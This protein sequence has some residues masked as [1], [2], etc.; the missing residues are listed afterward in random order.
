MKRRILSIVTALALCLSL[1]PTWAFAVEGEPDTGLCA[2]HREH[3]GCGYIAPTEGR[4]CGHRHTAEC[5]TL[6]VLPDGDSSEYYETGAD[7]EIL[8]CQHAHD[9]ECGYVQAGPGAPCGYECR[10][11]PIEDL[12]AAL[13]SRVTEDNRADVGAQLQKILDLCQE[14]NEE[15]REQINLS[16]CYA[17]QAELDAANEPMPLADGETDSVTLAGQTQSVI[18][19]ETACLEGCKGHTITQQGTVIISPTILVESGTHNITFQDLNLTDAEVGVMPGAAMNLTISGTNKIAAYIAGIYVPVGAALVITEQSTGS[20]DVSGTGAGAGIGGAC[21]DIS[22]PTGWRDGDP[23]CGTVIINGGTINATGGSSCAGIGGGRTDDVPGNGGNVTINGG[24]VTAT[25]GSD[26]A[27]NYG[28]AGIG[29]GSNGESGN[30]GRLTINGG[31]VTLAPGQYNSAYS[32][33][34]GFGRGSCNPNDSTGTCKLILADKSY[35]TVDSL[36]PKGT[37]TINADP[38]EDMIVVPTD[39]IYNG[40]AQGLDGK[41]YIDDTKTGTGIYFNQEFTVNASADGWVLQDLGAVVEA[42]EYTAIFKKG[43][44]EISKT[45]TVAKSGTDLTS[46]GKVQ[47]YKGDTLTKDFTAGDTIKVVATPTPTGAAPQKAAARLRGGEPTTGQMAVFVGD[48]QVSE[49]VNAEDSSYTMTVT[50]SDVLLAAGGPK[51]GITLIAKFVGNTSMADGAGTVTVNITAA[52]RAEKDGKVIGYYGESNLDKAFA[53]EN[54]GATVTLLKDVDLG[55]NDLILLSGTFTLDCGA[56]TLSSSSEYFVI[57]L[58]NADLTFAGGTIQ[59]GTGNAV[60]CAAG[61]FT[62]TGGTLN[63]ASDYA[64][65]CAYGEANIQGGTVGTQGKGLYIGNPNG[66]KLS[67]GTYA[68]ICIGSN[69]GTQKVPLSTILANGR[70]AYGPDGPITRDTVDAEL[71]GPIIVKECE[72]DGVKPT[73]N[74]NG[75]H[76]LKCPYCGYSGAAANCTYV[77]SGTTT[78][79]CATCGDSVTVAVS[80]TEN[81]TY[82]GTEKTLGVT[83]T[84]AGTELATSDYTIAYADN[85]NAGTATVTVTIGS[86][87]YTGNFSIGKATPTIEWANNEVTL[88]YTG[89]PADIKPVMTLVNGETFSGT[90][91]YTYGGYSGPNRPIDAASYTVKA[92]IPEQNNYTAATSSWMILYINRADQDAPDAPT[93]EDANIKDTSITLTVIENAE[94]SIDGTNWQESPEFTELSPNT[95]YTFYARLKE[96]RNHNASPSSA[97]TSITTKKMLVSDATVTVSGAYTY[98]GTAQTPTVTVVKNGKTLTEGT[99]YTVTCTNNTNAGTASITVTGM[100]D[101]E[102]TNSKTFTIRRKALTV[103]GATARDR[104]YNGANTVQITGVTLDGIVGSDEVSVDTANLTGTLNGSN[105]GRYTAVT[106]PALTLTGGGADNY[107][108]TRPAG[109]VSA[110]VTISKAPALTPKTGDLA[111]ANNQAHTYTFGLGALRPDLPAGMSFGSSA[112]TYELG[113]VSLGSYYDSSTN[114]AKIEGQTLTLPIKA[115]NNDKAEGIGTITVTIHTGNFEDMTATINVRSVN[116]IIPEGSPALSTDTLAYGQSISAITLSGSMKDGDKTVPG[117]F[118]WSSPDNRPAVQDSYDAAW[119]FTPTDN[120]AYAIVNGTAAIKVV[121]APITGAEITLSETAYR[122]DGAAHSPSITGVKLGDTTLTADTDYTAAIPAGTEAGTYTVTVTGKGNYTGTATIT[123][124]INPVETGNEFEGEGGTVLRLEVETGLSSV[125]AALE[126]NQKYDT[127][128]KIENELRTRVEQAMSNVGENIAVFDVTLQYKDKSGTWRNVDPNDF[129]KDGVTAIL[130]YPAG[131]GMTGYTFTVQHLISSGDK[132]GE[133]ETLSYELTADGLKCKFNSLSPVAIGYQAASKPVDP[134]NPTP[135]PP[136]SSGGGWSGVSTYAITVSKAAHGK[137]VS[138]CTN[139][140]S[141]STVTLT[142]TPDSGYVLDALTVTDSRGSEIKLIAQGDGKYTFTM[143]S[144]AVTVKAAFAPLPEDVEQPCDGGA[145]CPS[146]GFTDLGGVGTWYHEAVDYILRNGLMNGYSNGTFGPNDNLS[147]AMLAQI[148][149][150]RAGRPA[151]TGGSIFTDVT[152]GQWYTN[153]VIWANQNDIVGGYGNGM[154]GPN[155][156]ITREQLAVMLWRYAGSP[157][158]T[159]KE[160][161]FTDAD[162][163]GGWALDA[164]RWGTENGILNGYGD[165]RLGPKGLAT[166]AQVAQMLMNFLKDK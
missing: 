150:N 151:V 93:A 104:A 143:P 16:R 69:Y 9:G 3:T 5:Y 30:G 138:N 27:G 25:G 115:V 72:H 126:N 98:N 83:V 106:L 121:P 165:G 157:A 76:A 50:A 97:G 26:Q 111:V 163:A 31:H 13:P 74:N 99:D 90:I 53:A 105:V 123:F 46:E 6:G 153:A 127:P 12:I 21:V 130:P 100:G 41:I 19:T 37:Y 11:C 67:G 68:T 122:Y 58:D 28:G 48:T 107:T 57:K 14:L 43:D 109:A 7:A 132:A 32:T 81:L 55:E 18:F 160:L 131:T 82:D 24:T 63:A 129:P 117:V 86:G 161:H 87:T 118:T 10:I 88:T 29:G 45:F 85:T 156:N 166:R 137:V 136:S 158:A 51:T 149:Y 44:K 22:D 20:L 49:A 36:D 47:T 61:A 119:V 94:Y 84:R 120:N 133:M 89:Q 4:P 70:A 146:R 116:K 142:V 164:L 139:A 60:L 96:D 65:N 73:S 159:D 152:A 134:V 78:G 154:F 1:C 101:Y 102:G 33:A 91:T 39:L 113:T 110:S 35:L 8:D 71:T 38:T 135:T 64:L 145:D 42:K 148:L 125:P 34:Y 147:R 144:R 66:V 162:E 141:G 124:T 155:D 112:V 23:N 140:S 17:L 95:Q 54:T 40:K 15:E 59:N 80:G 52:A 92:S 103:T 79:T 62:M 2:H 77:F 75:T 128:E 114:S 56:F 108:L